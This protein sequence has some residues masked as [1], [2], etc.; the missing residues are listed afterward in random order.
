M[1][2]NPITRVF[3][4]PR[5]T[6]NPF[7]FVLAIKFPKIAACPLPIPGRKL[8]RGEASKAPIKGFLNLGFE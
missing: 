1:K 5:R 3:V 8:Q 2:E 6:R 4:A 7:R